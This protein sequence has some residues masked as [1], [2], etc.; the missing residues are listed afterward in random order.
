MTE[1]LLEHG[2]DAS[3]GSKV[4]RQHIPLVPSLRWRGSAA[5]SCVDADVWHTLILPAPYA[6]CPPCQNF[7]DSASPLHQAASRGML[8]ALRLL[9]KTGAAVDAA[10]EAGWTPLMLAVRSGKLPA[11]EA[12]LTA[13]ADAATQNQQGL[14]SLHLAAINGKTEICKSLLRKAPAAAT[15]LNSAG[16]TPAEVASTPE[17]AALLS[18]GGA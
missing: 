16:K 7:Q 11:V 6:S 9:L 12:L 17:L 2:A 10:D 18:S 3:L 4:R 15:A 1:L 8:Q 13:G 5:G 14:T